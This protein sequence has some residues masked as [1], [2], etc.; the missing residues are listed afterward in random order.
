MNASEFRQR[1]HEAAEEERERIVEY[2]RQASSEWA[3]LAAAGE[4]AVIAVAEALSSY[5][6][7]INQGE[8]NQ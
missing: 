3:A 4:A 6:E 5:A 2:L 1:M 8:H 7:S